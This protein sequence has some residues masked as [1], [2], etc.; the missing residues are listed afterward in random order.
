MSDIVSLNC[1][2]LEEIYYKNSSVEILAA[3]QKKEK[4]YVISNNLEF[5]NGLQIDL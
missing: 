1:E 4:I 5:P 2:D 3:L